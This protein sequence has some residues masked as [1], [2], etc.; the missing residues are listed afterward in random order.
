MADFDSAYAPLKQL[1]GGWC[2]NP[3]DKG[4]ETYA[5]IARNFFP[6]WPGWAVVDAAKSH[7][8][9]PAS[10]A[11]RMRGEAS[12]TVP[13]VSANSSRPLAPAGGSH[14]SA[15]AFSR[16]LA[17][18]PGLQ[19]MVTDWYRVEWW[20]RMGLARFPQAVAD[21]IFDQAVNLGRGGAG[22]SLQRLC[23]A[24]NYNKRADERLFPDLAEDGAIGPKT[25]AALSA[26]LER[27]S[28]EADVVHALNCLQGAHYIGLGAKSFRHRQFVDGWM[29]RTHCNPA[30][31]GK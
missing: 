18:I 2:H 20:E 1:E 6:A 27:R 31:A 29:R 28:D 14:G 15:R 4:G 22:R 24:L 10:A 17:A 21:E 30:D 25:L 11:G 23:N 26:I 16:H 8:S 12:S 13:A 7:P 9:F 5:G 19:D 3:D